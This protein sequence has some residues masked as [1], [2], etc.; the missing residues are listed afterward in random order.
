MEPSQ[1]PVEALQGVYTAFAYVTTGSYQIVPMPGQDEDLFQRVTD[2]KKR[3]PDTKVYVSIGGWTFNDNTSSTREVFTHIASNLFNSLQF[4]KNLALFMNQYGFDGADLDWEYPGAPDRSGRTQDV[5]KF[6]EMLQW[7][8]VAWNAYGK[9]DWG[10]TITVPTS[11]W[12]LRWFDLPALAKY[13]NYFNVMA[14]DLHGI[15]D[16]T[17]PIGPY[18]YAHTN[19][20]EI[21]L[22]LDLFWRSDI[23]GDMLNMG[24]AFY[25]RAFELKDP[26]CT[27]P[28]CEFS[29]PANEG[30]CTKTAGFLSW[31]EIQNILN[32]ETIDFDTRYDQTAGVNYM[33]WNQN[34]WISYDN[35]ETFQQKIEFANQR[36]I[37]GIFIWAIDQDDDY[38]NALKAVTG[39]DIAPTV[40]ES[41]TLGYWDVNKCYITHCGDTCLVGWTKMTGLNEDRDGVGC[42]NSS[43]DSQQ[44]S[45]CCPPW[46]APDP[47]TCNFYGNAQYCYGQ[48]APGEVLF[49]TDNFGHTGWCREGKKA[50]C[51]PATSGNEA[52]AACQTVWGDCPSETPH[53]MTKVGDRQAFC[54]PDSPT[55]NNCG[56][57]GDTTTCNNNRCPIGQIELT[58][59]QYGD[60]W[61]TGCV[62]GRQKAYCCDPPFDGT[63]F[64]PASLDQLFA[65]GDDFPIDEAPVYYEAFDHN[66]ETTPIFE[67]TYTDDPNKEPFAWTI[68]VGAKEDVQSLRR[69]DGSHLEAFDCPTPAADDFSTQ[70]LKL[71]CL[72][73]KSDH[74]CE[75]IMLGTVKGTIVRLP[76]DCGPDEWVRAVSF[77]PL[78]N[79]PI[80]S[81]LVKRAPEN[82]NIYQLRYDY[83]FRQLRRDGGEIHVRLDT[84][85]HAGYWDEIVTSNTD[86]PARKRSENGD[87][88]NWREF[89]LS[90]FKEQEAVRK[91]GVGEGD[92]W[93]SDRF[94][95]LLSGEVSY[96]IH[97]TYSYDQ[98]LYSASLSCPGN[99]DASVEARIGG[100]FETKL[101]FGISLIGTLRNFDFSQAYAYFR[102]RDTEM[103]NRA[104]LEAN[105]VFQM[106]SEKIPIVSDFDPFG[107]S[108]NLKGLWVVG[109]YFQVD[110]QLQALIVAS[111]SISAGVSIP[112]E[113]YT[114]MYPQQMG[115]SPDE[116]DIT[117][118]PIVD[119]TPKAGIETSAAL[120]IEGSATITI[121]PTMGFQI[122]LGALG[123]QLVDSKVSSSFTLGVTLHVGANSD[124]DCDGA[125]M[126]L[127]LN[128][129]ASIDLTNPLPGWDFVEDVNWE[130]MPLHSIRLKNQT[131][132]PW[133]GSVDTDT[134]VR[135]SLDHYSYLESRSLIDILFPDALASALACPT[136]FTSDTGD[137]T[138]HIPGDYGQILKR[139]SLSG[140]L[141][142]KPT[143]TTEAPTAEVLFRRAI[144]K[145]SK[146]ESFYYCNVATWLDSPLCPG[147]DPTCNNKQIE[148]NGITYPASGDLVREI[149]NNQGSYTTYGPTGGCDD[150]TF[151][152]VNTPPT[153]TTSDWAAEHILEWQLFQDFLLDFPEYAPFSGM[154]FVN[155]ADA[156]YIGAPT[157][158]TWQFCTY[159]WFWWREA[160]VTYQGLT[161]SG[162]DIVAK[163]FPNNVFNKAELQLLDED[164]NKM[165]ERIWGTGVIRTDSTMNSYMS[166]DPNV[167]INVVR[168]TMF[169]VQYQ[170]I[171]SVKDLLVSQARRIGTWLDDIENLLVAGGIVAG[172]NSQTYTKLNLGNAWRKYVYRQWSGA[173]VKQQ[174]FLRAWVANIVRKHTPGNAGSAAG[175]AN[176][177]GGQ[178]NTAIV[179]RVKKMK[180]AYDAFLLTPWTNPFPAAWA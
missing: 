59:S 6:P 56:W 23:P 83:N 165:K 126:A 159:M 152:T 69:R 77:Q 149:N 133:S 75:D 9:S 39:K 50:F 171:T 134:K 109:P 48:C 60:N 81:H 78:E 140:V 144:E 102:M 32:S 128:A 1:I 103:L 167:A 116:D 104:V 90:W 33:V 146:K 132:I 18:V 168:H 47:S 20:T 91:R 173:N 41:D 45:L 66:A 106:E 31:R 43:Q 107:G 15:W 115:F 61:W 112:I 10:L 28:G 155:Q 105:A 16:S 26:S 65:D 179:N 24:L 74:N 161:G 113:D 93:W 35:K 164:T 98:V 68:M 151:D 178:T 29:G 73:D 21:D 55:W 76:E 7:I 40:A 22:A 139:D 99:V 58:R 143:N 53:F 57:H 135:R 80:P 154:T 127:D 52:V 4:G 177:G 120:G 170:Q 111:G 17:D 2:I 122:Q 137:C 8:R 92:S 96:G 157:A 84:S 114:W 13:V 46:S 85:D 44:R 72:S 141:Y 125:L 150:Y 158:T 110:A 88:E 95:A 51:C 49:A 86:D 117:L 101:D 70:T 129:G 42:P 67:N 174:D 162:M 11:Y 148:V 37:H 118:N 27:T 82:A 71:V 119:Y 54:C 160:Q 142:D 130:V 14:Y 136:D 79:H 108:F 169:A 38:F 123:V 147:N 5:S 87:N 176:A 34:Q 163:S 3:S 145:R 94:T 166:N 64:I 131:C 124:G 180:D 172:F 12:Y 175:G 121:Y 156:N 138:A 62:L 19:L 153:G 63:A 30:P 89:H 97:H 36:G 25:G 100:N